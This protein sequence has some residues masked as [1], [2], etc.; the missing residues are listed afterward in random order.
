MT[1][2]DISVSYNAESPQHLKIFSLSTCDSLKSFPI[3]GH[4][5]TSWGIKSEVYLPFYNRQNLLR[6]RRTV[7]RE[8]GLKHENHS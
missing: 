5:L 6:K 1:L 2:H 3:L 8:T 7:G 4:S